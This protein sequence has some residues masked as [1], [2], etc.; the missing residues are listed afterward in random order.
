M[1]GQAFT[2]RYISVREKRSGLDVSRDAD[3]PQ[4]LAVETCPPNQIL[5][6]DAR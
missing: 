3:H 5:V 4:R 2:L 1:V 6:I